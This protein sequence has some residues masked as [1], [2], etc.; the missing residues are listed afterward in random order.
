MRATRHLTYGASALLF[1]LSLV[2]PAQAEA[3]PPVG[4]G[5]VDVGFE[6]LDDVESSDEDCVGPP[7]KVVRWT[8]AGFGTYACD[9]DAWEKHDGTWLLCHTTW[10]DDD[11]NSDP[12]DANASIIFHDCG[13]LPSGVSTT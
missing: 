12:H 9:R 1:L 3:V 5:G 6:C 11:V 8:C 13:T 10:L 7:D 4:D 2:T